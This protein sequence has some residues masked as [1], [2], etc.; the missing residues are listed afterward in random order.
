MARDR[1][2]NACGNEL[3]G[4]GYPKRCSRCG[5]EI[6]ANPIPVG[7]SLVPIEN[8][9]LVV[10]RGIPPQIGKLTLPGGFLE[11]HETWQT[12]CAREVFEETQIEIDP[13]LLRLH[14]VASTTPDP[15]HVLIFALAPPT[16]IT[17]RFVTTPETTERGMISG[18]G[19]IDEVFAFPTHIAAIR[20]YFAMRGVAGPHQF[21]PL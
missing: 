2:C 8:G 14:S 6:W 5:L 9:L 10:R 16:V 21:R 13:T 11:P 12:G 7:V 15:K 18:P 19:G 3:A 20:S 4:D 1:F 17:E